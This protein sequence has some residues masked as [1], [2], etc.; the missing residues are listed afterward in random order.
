MAYVS[1]AV[2]DAVVAIEGAYSPYGGG[3]K[4]APGASVE[5]AV[6]EAAYRTLLHYLPGQSA[7][8]NP[9]YTAAL[10][11][12]QDGQSKSDGLSVGRAASNLVIALRTN[13]GRMGLSS[14]S[15]FPHKTPGPGV[16]RLTPTA[17]AARQTPWVGTVTPFL[18]DH[19]DRFLPDLP[20]SLLSFEWV[21]A[22]NES[23]VRERWEHQAHAGT[24][25][26]GPVLDGQRDSSV[27][28]GAPRCH[29]HEGPESARVGAAPRPW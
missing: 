9:L 29:R 4:A 8:L 7:V 28:P 3:V 17:Y 26:H 2:Y 10:A 25:Q 11:G 24:E 1:A 5:A 20:P 22:D 13:D 12:I 15:E 14:T 23:G 27:Q 19:V 18:V 6:I 16:W 21:E